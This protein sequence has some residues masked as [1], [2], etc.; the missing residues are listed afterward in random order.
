MPQYRITGTLTFVDGSPNSDTELVETASSPAAAISAAIALAKK[1]SN[2]E[3]FINVTATL[4]PEE[5][6]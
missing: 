4:Y 6:D 1:Q 3:S 5:Q 2:V